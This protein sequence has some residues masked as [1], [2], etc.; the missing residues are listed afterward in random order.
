MTT[1]YLVRHAEAQGN[2]ERTF[3]GHSNGKL[4]KNGEQ[5]LEYLKKRFRKIALHAVYSSPLRRAVATAKAVNYHAELPLLIDPSLMEICGGAFEG[6]KFDEIPELFP[7]EW[8]TWENEPHKFVAPGGESMR[9]CFERMKHAVSEIVHAN[10]G[11]SVA[12]IS[13][14]CALRNYLCHITDT[15]FEM[16]EEIAWGDNTCV[17]R[18]DFDDRFHPKVVYLNDVSHLPEDLSTLAKQTWWRKDGSVESGV[19]DNLLHVVS[20]ELY[21]RDDK[22]E[23]ASGDLMTPQGAVP[24]SN[25]CLRVGEGTVY[26]RDDKIKLTEP[27]DVPERTVVLEDDVVFDEEQLELEQ[28]EPLSELELAPDAD[29][30]E[31][32]FEQITV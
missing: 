25:V 6:H 17:S 27:E 26:L 18:I 10:M 24:L 13:H 21:L 7:T 16:L 1:I 19:E 9:H 23:I 29:F 11:Y 14:G 3:Q 4:T 32:T 30:A 15:P 31:E 22:M 20:G 5:Q 8:E 2:A 12:I 28:E